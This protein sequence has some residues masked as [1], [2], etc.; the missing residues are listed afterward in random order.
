[1]ANE[2]RNWAKPKHLGHTY[3][4]QVLLEM[5]DLSDDC[6]ICDATIPQIAETLEVST[7]SVE[8]GIAFLEEIKLIERKEAKRKFGQFPQKITRINIPSE[9][10]AK[11]NDRRAKYGLAPTDCQSDGEASQQTDSPLPTDSQPVGGDN[12][13]TDSPPPT[14]QESNGLTGCLNIGESEGLNLEEHK[15]DFSFSAPARASAAHVWRE[16]YPESEL[17]SEQELQLSNR[18]PEV[19]ESV[20][21]QNLLDWRLNKWGRNNISGQINRYKTELE[22]HEKS[23]EEKNGTLSKSSKNGNKR[24]ES[25]RE[26]REYAAQKRIQFGD[27]A[28]DILRR[29]GII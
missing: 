20:W 7:K 10:K 1:M 28:D 17:D 16:V 2:I 5:A 14:D 15:E 3:A 13:Q 18:L 9:V 26:R 8:R 21:R 29:E 25:E 24:F 22:K 11:I 6:G 12:R 19:V 27:A 4:K 23:E